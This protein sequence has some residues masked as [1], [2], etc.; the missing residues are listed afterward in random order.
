MTL[1]ALV[2]LP[3]LAAVVVLLVGHRGGRLAQWTGVGTLGATWL[4]AVEVGREHLGAEYGSTL[5]ARSVATGGVPLSPSLAV[6]ALTA[7]MLLLVTSVAL[8]VSVYSV[9]FLARDPRGPSYTALLLLFTAAMSLVVAAD[10]LFVLL[11]GWEVM[12]ACSY[13]L[14]AHYWEQEPARAGAVRAFV[15]TRLGDV[16]L[17]FG[18]FVAGRAA[19]TYRISGMLTAV[20]TGQV[21][22]GQATAATLLMLC[23]VAGK[24]AQFPLHSWLPDAMPGP[25]PITAL[26]HAA[27]MVAAGVYLVARLLPLFA[28]STVTMDV[29]AGIAVVSMVGGA[30]FAL[31]AAD[32]KRVLA[33][34]TVSQLAYMF[35]ALALGG[36]GVGLLH[37]LSHG[38]FKALL[39]LAAGSVI[40]SS[41]TQRLDELGGLW[42]ALPVTFVT[43]TVGF[44]ALAGVPPFVGFFS[45]DA[46]LGL[47][48]QQALDGSPRAWVVLV[49]GLLGAALTAAYATRAWLMVFCGGSGRA[50]AGVSPATVRG[51]D[52]GAGAGAAPG[53]P[54]PLMTVPLV[55]LAVV[56]TLGGLLV[57]HPGFLHV[58]ADTVDM[59]AVT[60]GLAVLVV[61]ATTTY[62]A[63]LRCGRRDP[64]VALGDLRAA[65]IRE[66]Y[67]DAVIAGGPVRV[68]G[69]A[70]RGTAGAESDVVAPYVR[71]AETTAQL[72]GRGLRWLH[73]GDLAGYLTAVVV[74][75][76]VAALA[77]GWVQR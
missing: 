41:G 22:T 19:G 47:A 8:L 60:A 52:L 11:V 75:A 72:A 40:A 57:L 25:T 35:A 15:L 1:C 56:S 7:T 31:V 17:L 63:W 64:A 20:T 46:V 42:R 51:V 38:A 59:R 2:G 73:G 14:I 23:G 65:L 13:L 28:M 32:L 49:G 29:L 24:S 34:S 74:G 21:S 62:A 66:G 44:A 30:A 76:A 55:L 54:S 3:A 39:F 33:W 4:L 48:L 77:V 45:K 27:T 67:A 16:G 70:I 6:D 61:G 43:A 50:R 9:A 71:G 18:I 12:G 68:V 10:D 36:Y 26:I 5:V 53:E 37:L 69:V 58:A